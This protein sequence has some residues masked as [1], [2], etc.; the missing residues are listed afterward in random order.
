ME[1]SE[2]LIILS[3]DLAIFARSILRRDKIG[4]GANIVQI[5][6]AINTITIIIL[7][8]ITLNRY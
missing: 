3:G 6:I 4:G 2:K 1:F 7:G 8:L 5:K